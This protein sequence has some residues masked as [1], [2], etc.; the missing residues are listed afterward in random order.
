MERQAVT[1]NSR[2]EGRRGDRGRPENQPM[3]ER[4]GTRSA[5]R[6]QRARKSMRP[7]ES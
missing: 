6:R 7:A 1:E 2:S 4:G 3:R 5:R